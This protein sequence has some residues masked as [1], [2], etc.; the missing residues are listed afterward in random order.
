MR[1]SILADGLCFFIRYVYEMATDFTLNAQPPQVDQMAQLTP[2]QIR[3]MVHSNVSIFMTRAEESKGDRR[4]QQEVTEKRKEA[5]EF[6][7]NYM[8]AH[9]VTNVPIT[10]HA[11]T[12][13][14]VIKT[15]KKKHPLNHAFLTS[16]FFT[17]VNSPEIRTKCGQLTAQQ[18]GELF[19][20]L[21][22]QWQESR[23]TTE[24][25]LRVLKQLPQSQDIQDFTMGGGML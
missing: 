20:Q 1:R 2:D 25:K 13:Y 14:M 3:Q 9:Q 5:E 11:G 22:E 23:G 7:I 18:Q 8:T 21:C 19:A 12:Q 10:T 6:L 16:A 4:Q 24:R 15:I 17:F